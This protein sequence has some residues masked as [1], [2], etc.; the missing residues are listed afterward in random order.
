[1]AKFVVDV[2]VAIKWVIPEIYTDIAI[3]L[4]DDDTNILLVP[5]FFFSE[6]GNVFWKKIKR[7]ELTLVQ[8]QTNLTELTQINLQIFSS[9]SLVQDALEIASK[10]DQAVYDCVYL[11]LAINHNARMVTADE[12]FVNAISNDPLSSYVCWIEDLPN[13]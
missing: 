2:N 11:T 5:D 10:I 9:L 6:I 8:A 13:I 3:T 1:M 12:R 4:L 7:G